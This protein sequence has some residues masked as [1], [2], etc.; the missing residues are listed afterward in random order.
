[1]NSPTVEKAL[2]LPRVAKRLLAVLV[3]V[4]LCVGTVWAW[5]ALRTESLGPFGPQ[6][7]WVAG[8]SVAL[9]LPLMVHFGL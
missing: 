8:A 6:L 1:M 5:F 9:A 4:C 3:D 7:W 2:A